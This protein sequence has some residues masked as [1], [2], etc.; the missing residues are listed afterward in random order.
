MDGLVDEVTLEE[1]KI[2]YGIDR[3]LYTILVR[4]LSHNPSECLLIM[5]FW[6]WLERGCYCNIISKILSLDPL[7]IDMAY[8]EALTFLQLIISN[9][10]PIPSSI[11]VPLTCL[12]LKTDVPLQYLRENR[13]TV[14]H[15]VQNLVSD[16]CVPAL[17]DIMELARNDGIHESPDQNV[18]PVLDRPTSLVRALTYDDL[19]ARGF[20]GLQIEGDS[21]RA[22]TGEAVIPRFA[23]TMFVTFS[24]GYPV[25]ETEVRE[26][27][28]KLFGNCIESLY[29][30]EVEPDRQALYARIVFVNSSFIQFILNGETKA[31]FSINGKHVW[32]RQFV[33][34]NGR[35]WVWECFRQ[36]GP[37]HV[38]T[39]STD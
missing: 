1:F 21:G 19:I 22:R 26:F 10:L 14:F 33:P 6:L 16:V 30:Q 4:D 36:W 20:L 8:D 25:T 9:H 37:P 34:R 15:H 2:F 35:M 32:M 27:F 31:K 29:M 17:S 12:L 24:K 13:R 18:T 7:L 38:P 11:G 23:R 28:M 5:G 39:N 3:E